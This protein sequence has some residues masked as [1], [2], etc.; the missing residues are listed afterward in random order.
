LFV[1]GRQHHSVK[2]YCAAEI[3]LHMFLTST[4]GGGELITSGFVVIFSD[5]TGFENVL[6]V[7]RITSRCC[8][9]L[10]LTTG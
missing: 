9:L 10:G 8:S 1:P 2:A 4:L 3:K 6:S 7:A 5:L